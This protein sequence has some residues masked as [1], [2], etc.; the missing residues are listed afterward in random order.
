MIGLLL[1]KQNVFFGFFFPTWSLAHLKVI[2][3]WRFLGV[4]DAGGSGTLLS[5]PSQ[6][7]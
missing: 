7:P 3:F 6:Q 4:G 1:M 2:Q 5:T